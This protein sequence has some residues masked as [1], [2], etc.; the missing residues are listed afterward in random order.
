M[1]CNFFVQFAFLDISAMSVNWY[2]LIGMSEYQTDS[3]S[4]LLRAGFVHLHLLKRLVTFRCVLE[5]KS[6]K[7]FTGH[8]SPALG[9]AY[10]RFSFVFSDASMPPCQ[11]DCFKSFPFCQNFVIFVCQITWFR[12]TN[13]HWTSG[14]NV[15][16][17]NSN[18]FVPF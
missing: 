8:L 6:N 5:M 4:C 12:W 2:C 14:V 7:D 10:I 1:L 18:Q 16:N 9:T 15:H 13:Q 11:Y 3:F 17:K